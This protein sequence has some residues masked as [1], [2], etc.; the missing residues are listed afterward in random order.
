MKKTIQ[1]FINFYLS[2]LGLPLI[3]GSWA[4]VFTTF[5]MQHIEMPIFG[6]TIKVLPLLLAGFM[7]IPSFISALIIKYLDPLKKPEGPS[8]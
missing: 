5:F 6:Q 2:P 4:F 8:K 1:A 7:A 3:N